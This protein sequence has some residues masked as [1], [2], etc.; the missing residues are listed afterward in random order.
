MANVGVSSIKLIDSDGDA[1]D[2]GAGRLNVNATLSEASINIGDVDVLSVPAPLNVV[3]GGTEASA[4]RVTIAN[5]STGVITVD[6]TV[7]A[8]LSATDNAVLDSIASAV[9]A[10]DHAH[11]TADKGIPPLAVRRDDPTTG[12]AG[13]GDYI[14]LSTDAT[15]HLYVTQGNFVETDTFTMIDVDNGVEGL[16]TVDSGVVGTITNCVEIFLQADESNS[17]YIMVGDGDVADNRGVKLNPGD[18]II[19]NINDTRQVGLWGSADNQNLRCMITKR[20]T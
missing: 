4:L 16:N 10:E 18:T 13:D 17:G 9:H 14:N 11:S 5:N 2:D 8:N 15:G 20:T 12:T 6:G 3:G 19:L 1:L 7:T